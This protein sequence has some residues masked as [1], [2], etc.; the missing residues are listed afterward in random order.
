MSA[1]VRELGTIAGDTADWNAFI[2]RHPDANLYHTLNWRDLV[3]EVFGHRPFYLILGEGEDVRGVLPMFEARFPVLG[4]KMI[5]LPYD[6]GSGGALVRDDE[7]ERALAARAIE[8][9]RKR[10]VNFVQLR[11]GGP[12]PALE[13]FEGLARSEPVII[14]DVELDDRDQVWAR[15]TKDHQKSIKK[16]E[17]RD[18][19]IREAESFDDY[20]AFYRIYLEVFRAFG[21]PPYPKRYFRALWDRLRPSGG[22]RLLLAEVEGRIVGGLQLFCFNRELVSKFAACLPQAVPLRAYAALY[23]RAMELGL[24]EGYAHLSWGTSSRQQQGLIEFKE[25]WGAKSRPAVFYDL[26]VRRE[27]PSV[28]A[29]YDSDGLAQRAWRKMPVALTP[30]LGDW[31]NRWFC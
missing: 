31:I 9:A 20:L 2:D 18:V 17:K 13:G 28:E 3:A 11:Y 6:I 4:S 10:S 23:W 21:T 25:R 5:S 12:R 22:I 1:E 27:V 30:L 24:D 15:I 14:S 8:I 7:A 19:E 29:Y 16:A 26:P